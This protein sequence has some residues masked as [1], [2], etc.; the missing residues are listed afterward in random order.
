MGLMDLV[1]SRLTRSLEPD[2]AQAD[3]AIALADPPVYSRIAAMLEMYTSGGMSSRSKKAM[4][5]LKRII[6]EALEEARD[7]PPEM[8]ESELLKS[9]AV[10]YW[11]ATG[12]IPDDARPEIIDIITQYAEKHGTE[13]PVSVS[14]AITASR[15]ETP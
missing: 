9:S 7:F 13:I 8:V 4:F 1:Q 15:V 10:L 3:T 5:L 14:K 6:D 11:V 12:S 2:T